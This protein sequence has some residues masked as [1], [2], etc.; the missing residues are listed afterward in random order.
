MST[1]WN[2]KLAWVLRDLPDA[3]L[4]LLQLSGHRSELLG[5]DITIEVG[6]RADWLASSADRVPFPTGSSGV[7][8]QVDWAAHPE[9]T[10]PLAKAR[11]TGDPIDL[12]ATRRI[13]GT[14]LAESA[15]RFEKDPRRLL[16][17]MWRYLPDQLAAAPGGP[18][19]IASQ[20][21]A[22]PRLP[23][24]SVWQRI[25]FDSALAGAS[26]APT[27]LALQISP[28]DAALDECATVRDLWNTSGIAAELA[29]KAMLPIVE[30]LGPEAIL[31]PCLRRH[32]KVDAWLAEQ[33]VTLA[34]AQAA[35]SASLS[36]S[37]PSLIV[38]LV[39]ADRAR[40][41]GDACKKSFEDAWAQ[42]S[43]TVRDR[44]VKDGWV[45]AGDEAWTS[46]W[47]RQTS[48]AWEI[49]W[50]AVGWGED[51]TGAGSLLPKL[52]V[53]ALEKWARLQEDAAG[54]EE[55]WPGIFYGLWYN[56][57]LAAASA[58]QRMGTTSIL[59]E[60]DRPCTACGSREA[61]HDGAVD[62]DM[63]A[64]RAFWKPLSGASGKTAGTIQE[65]EHLCCICTTRRLGVTEMPK[66][67]GAL[68]Q[69]AGQVALVVFGMDQPA[70]L[71]RGTKDLKQGATL[72][73][74][75]HSELEKSFTKRARTH[76]KE[77]LDCP[78]HLG[79]AR[80]LAVQEV[81]ADFLATAVPPLLDQFGAFAVHATDRE[82]TIAAPVE[83]VY[84]L[85]RA[86]RAQQR[87][88]FVEMDT[89]SGKRLALRAG[90]QSTS[91][92]IVAIVSKSEIFGA[93]LRDCRIMLDD[94]ARITLGGDAL[95]IVRRSPR[96]EERV[97]AARW[98]ELNTSVDVLVEALP[99][100][101]LDRMVQGLKTIAPALSN[102]D[103]DKASPTARPSLAANALEELGFAE[104]KVE[105]LARAVCQLV[106]QCV[107]LP[108]G[109]E[110]NHALD[111]LHI[112]AS[113]CGADQ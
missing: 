29:W 30:A 102:V 101:E 99:A 14:L 75:V 4:D 85:V 67:L 33:G 28:P 35:S 111:G 68:A 13:L 58:R 65:G 46:L 95:V 70:A 51:S 83:R 37:L 38:A 60:P 81:F 26:P 9:I 104:D 94:L 108:T 18:G 93:L 31:S 53:T 48:R 45:K 54:L 39:P 112:A 90:P 84:P 66:S 36:G 6:P 50:T 97:F 42:M 16:L 15:K 32:P 55:P 11:Y 91:S 1:D 96:E 25:G 79:P 10:H 23:N 21:P 82:L 17:W 69:G 106:D 64:I 113:L 107:R 3:Q 24:L 103:L 71:L 86:L 12:E 43:A 19:P 5:A 20:I 47:A 27:F 49:H 44:L 2:Q 110:E 72:A 76:V 59:C 74:S 8:T 62:A 89:A 109:T 77:I 57:A 41:L 87:E 22:D 34:G 7:R 56:A 88:A 105:P 100:A 80:Q 52:D 40:E 73:D 61:L 92:A 63:Q 98:D 78:A